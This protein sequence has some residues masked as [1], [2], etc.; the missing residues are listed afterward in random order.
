MFIGS[1]V[2]IG[3]LWP[4]IS[5]VLS[6]VQPGDIPNS[7]LKRLLSFSSKLKFS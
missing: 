6:I 5:V 7:S 1:N 3:T 4:F 2:C